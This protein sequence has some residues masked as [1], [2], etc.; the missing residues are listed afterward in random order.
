LGGEDSAYRSVVMSARPPDGYEVRSRIEGRSGRGSRLFVAVIALLATGWLAVTLANRAGPAPSGSPSAPVSGLRSPAPSRATVPPAPTP[1]LPSLP[2]LISTFPGAPTAPFPV[3]LN[4]LSWISPSMSEVVAAVPRAW[5][6]WPFLLP[7]GTALCVCL[8]PV[9]EA[10]EASRLHLLRLGADGTEQSDTVVDWS[11]SA[12]TSGVFLDS[13]LTADGLA[14]IVAVAVEREAGWSIHLDRI[15]LGG[16]GP[17]RTETSEVARIPTGALRDGELRSLRLWLSPDG[18]LARLETGG[19]HPSLF[20]DGVPAAD[21]RIVSIETGHFGD[22]VRIAKVDQDATVRCIPAAWATAEDFVSICADQDAGETGPDLSV[23]RDSVDGTSDAVVVGSA[24]PLA[25][26]SWLVNASVGLVYGWS[27]VSG[28]LIQVRVPAMAVVA[29]VIDVTG[30][31]QLE[32]ETGPPPRG[33][34]PSVW[35]SVPFQQAISP[36]VASPDGSMLYGIGS[37]S[38]IYAFD[39]ETLGLVGRWD[40]AVVYEAIGVSPDGA[41]LFGVGDPDPRE[42]VTFGDQGGTLAVHAADTGDQVLVLRRIDTRLEGRPGFLLPRPG[43]R[44]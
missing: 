32:P 31:D 40:A 3:L 4:G 41:Y 38:G 33:A 8:E 17:R 19:E 44:P 13:A 36:F 34:Q 12:A 18:K 28:D 21:V 20:V 7:D 22:I 9:P 5:T 30:H 29:R 42:V 14:A 27:G 16:D 11:G 39:A 23:H 10:G 43:P 37:D 6:Q 15:E 1:A 24:L 2:P 25:T 26:T 35:E